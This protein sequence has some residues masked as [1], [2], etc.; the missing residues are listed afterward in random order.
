MFDGIDQHRVL[1]FNSVIVSL[2]NVSRVT[3][4]TILAFAPLSL[5]EC[6][7]TIAPVFR[8]NI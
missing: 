1:T 7:R 8:I 6:P 2:D 5:S 4:I 3:S